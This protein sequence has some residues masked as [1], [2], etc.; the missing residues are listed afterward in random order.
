MNFGGS[1][2]RIIVFIVLVYIIFHIQ[3]EE[4]RRERLIISAIQVILIS[5]K[6]TKPETI[7]CKNN[8]KFVCVFSSGFQRTKAIFSHAGT[9][10]RSDRR[11]L[12]SDSGATLQSG[13]DAY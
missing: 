5:H 4:C 3:D 13:C 9:E 11:L 7:R 12:E 10:A 6:T 8:M 1:Y 2:D